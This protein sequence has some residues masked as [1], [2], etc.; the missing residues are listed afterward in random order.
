V[1]TKKRKKGCTV[2]GKVS[3]SI[4]P[5]QMRVAPYSLFFLPTISW[6]VWSSRSPLTR[7]LSRGFT[8]G[9]ATPEDRPASADL[10]VAI[11]R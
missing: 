5:C 4:Q 7:V 10:R 8:A 9:A 2:A 1:K 3:G 6:T 11:S